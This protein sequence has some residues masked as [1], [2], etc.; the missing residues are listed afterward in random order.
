M[1]GLEYRK[2][3]EMIGLKKRDISR[4]VLMIFVMCYEYQLSFTNVLKLFTISKKYF[5]TFLEIFSPMIKMGVRKAS[6]LKKSVDK[7]LECLKDKSLTYELLT[8]REEKML[9]S[10]TWFIEDNFSD[11]EGCLH[12]S[13]FEQIPFAKAYL[14][15]GLALN[16]DYKSMFDNVDKIKYIEMGGDKFFKTSKFLYYMEKYSGDTEASELDSLSV[17]EMLKRISD[18]AEKLYEKEK[19]EIN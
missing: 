15:N 11:G 9:E 5:W 1:N 10:F 12:I 8:P 13:Q 18:G 3:E 6:M 14:E 7:M 4:D 2:R 17:R 16:S 19:S